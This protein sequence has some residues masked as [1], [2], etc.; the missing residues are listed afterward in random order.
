M[1]EAKRGPP[2]QLSAWQSAYGKRL[3]ALGFFESGDAGGYT[4]PSELV[5]RAVEPSSEEDDA[6]WDPDREEDGEDADDDEM[7]ALAGEPEEE[8]P[9]G[10]LPVIA[11]S[12]DPDR[13]VKC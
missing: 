4:Y 5:R 7:E 8:A 3:D 9:E 2:Q 1:N 13:Y 12:Q 10:V 11:Q 6:A